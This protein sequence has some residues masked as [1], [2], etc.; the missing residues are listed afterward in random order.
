MNARRRL[1]D[2]LRDN[3]S[4]IDSAGN[5]ATCPAHDDKAPSLS[6][7]RRTDRTGVLLRCHAGCDTDEVLAALDLTRA[8]LFDEPRSNGARPQ[9]VATY[10]YRDEAGTL[11]YQAVRYEPK[12]FRQRRPDG[13]GGW[14][15]SL[16]GTR[17]VLY[18]L[19]SVLAAA[20]AHQTVY[21][22]E[23]EKD[24]HAV[25]RA[26]AVGT[27]NSGGAAK[28]KPHHTAALVGANVVV[29]ADRDTTGRDHAR[30]VLA[31]L[32]RAGVTARIVEAASG[33]DTSDHL[34]AGLT[35]ADLVPVTDEPPAGV[36]EVPEVA[37]P[38]GELHRGQMRVAERF[39]RMHAEHLRHVHGVGWHVWDG[40]RWRLDTSGAAVRAGVDTV[41][42][43]YADLAGLGRDA[44]KELIADIHRCESASGLE[45]A[46]RLAANMLPLAVAV[47]QLDADPFLLN[48]TNGTL[49][50]RTG[51]LRPHD[52]A[53]LI[54]KVA[55]CAYESDATS[56]TFERFLAEILPDAA[57]R[58]FVAR[59]FGHALEGRVTEHLLAI[60][61]GTGCNGKTTLAEV[62][63]AAYGDYA[64]ACEP[65]LLTERGSVHTTGTADLLGVRLAVCSETDDGRRLA[66]AT[67]KRLTGGD[68]VRAR[69][70]R[71]DNIE[72]S[73]S[74]T[75]LMVTNHKPTVAG[76]DPA[77]WRRLRIIPFDVV[78]ADPDRTL[79]ERLILEL[80]AV[81]AWVVAGHADWH[82]D[83]LAEPD[84]VTSAT[85]TYRASSDVLGRFFDD[86]IY[87]TEF[88]TVR[89]RELFAAWSAWCQTNGEAAGTENSLAEAM[90]QRGHAKVKRRGV[91]TY[92]GVTLLDAEE[93]TS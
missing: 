26:G 57:V 25:E 46:M 60:L 80:P 16:D 13:N 64:I 62:V 41:K 53:D 1:L 27:C 51:H 85:D 47:D 89:A 10:D 38:V 18:K 39:V 93:G 7:G 21:V 68:K 23:G 66:A 35:L 83:G 22:V 42:S 37:E 17:G 65:D 50:L 87:L 28:W 70:M 45:G 77:L 20:K 76:N 36:T 84:A 55:G 29:V 69:R 58:R 34:A 61:T 56:A 78:V 3:G 19:P 43:A 59:V 75:V 15:W 2:A 30:G 5:A 74:H 71:Q 79:K 92:R 91:M 73:P 9:I 40:T 81:L 54:T 90:A 6:I 48:V 31:S 44:Q 12:G 52:P 24:V 8:D 86:H 32:R 67:V 88:G 33:N 49:D 14:V 4:T 63:Q 82:R 72:W 11:L